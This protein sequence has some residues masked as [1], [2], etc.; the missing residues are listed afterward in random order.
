MDNRKANALSVIR[1]LQDI[2][3]SERA[4]EM[5]IEKFGGQPVLWTR[6]DHLQGGTVTMVAR[7]RLKVVNDKTGKLVWLHA[8]D[9]MWG[10]IADGAS[11][12]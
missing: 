6:G 1:D 11:A 4:L 8:T 3:N 9:I 12:A 10:E 5:D 2:K 7:D